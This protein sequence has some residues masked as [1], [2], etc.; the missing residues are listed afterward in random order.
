M[1]LIFIEGVPGVGKSTAAKN[2]CNKLKSAGYKAVR[3]LE[4]ETNNPIDLYWYAYLTKAEYEELLALNNGIAGTVTVNSV[5]EKDYVLVRY[6]DFD[7]RYFT[8]EVY[9]YLKKREVCYKA[10][11]PV[12][13]NIFTQ[14]F[15][16]RWHAFL[17]GDN[18]NCDFAIFDG[19][20]MA[21]QLNDMI[22]NY[23]TDDEAVL[24]HLETIL[25]IINIF[26]PVIFYLESQDIWER[27]RAANISRGQSIPPKEQTAFWENRKRLDLLALDKLPLKS[28]RFDISSG[29]WDE[30]TDKMF[31]IIN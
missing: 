11:R 16:D 21:H 28:Y 4:A 5:I 12:P 23:R 6:Q 19:T 17:S 26:S 31:D 15:I 24:R 29:N 27:L 20:F 10:E 22:R 9:N 13:F 14:I 1:K 25:Q 18:I 8:P 30:A 2:L 7:K 3:F